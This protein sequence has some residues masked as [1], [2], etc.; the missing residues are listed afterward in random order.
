MRGPRG[1]KK[2][3]KLKVKPRR[4]GEKGGEERKEGAGVVGG[5]E[6][7][8]ARG[9]SPCPPGSLAAGTDR[10]RLCFSWTHHRKS[11]MEGS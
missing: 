6:G 5:K 1:V 3:S 9:R 10:G 7:D 11:P 4:K 2:R 8:L